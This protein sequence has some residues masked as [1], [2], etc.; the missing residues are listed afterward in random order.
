[1]FKGKV[2]STHH[3]TDATWSKWIALITQR[4]RMGIPSHP[5]ILEVIMDWPKGKDFRISPEEKVMHD[6]E[7][8]QYNKLPEN[9]MK[10]ALFTY[11]SCPSRGGR[12]PYGALHNKLQKLL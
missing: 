7:A 8:S 6:E 11:G 3:A 10:C 2:P 1:M 9:E 4:A 5:G 12:L